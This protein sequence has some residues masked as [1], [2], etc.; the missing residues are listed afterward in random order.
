MKKDSVGSEDSEKVVPFS[1]EWREKILRELHDDAVA[2]REKIRTEK[3]ALE[4]RLVQV[5]AALTE[6]AAERAGLE[7]KLVIANAELKS[8]GS[9]EAS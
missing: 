2:R 7:T 1:A 6:L 3:S 5:Q 8:L 4:A 9:E